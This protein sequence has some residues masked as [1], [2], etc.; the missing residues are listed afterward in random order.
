M[1][2]YYL[3]A[4]FVL[5]LAFAAASFADEGT[6]DSAEAYIK[7]WVATFN[8]NDPEQLMAFYDNSEQI[9]VIVS[10]GVRFR[11]YKAVQKAYRGD[12]KILRH[13]D[14]TTKGIS[15][16]ILGNTAIVTFEHL[17]KV[18]FLKDNAHWQLHVRTTSVL[19]RKEGKWKIV[20]DHSSPIQGI[21][22][23]KQIEE[24]KVEDPVRVQITKKFAPIRQTE[25][26]FKIFCIGYDNQ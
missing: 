16:R 11:G 12:Q 24:P 13:Y 15:T 14:S 25:S 7:D 3:A 22:R 2:W 1:R 10:S 17:F 9:E 20:L 6:A 8:K 18:R 4:A 26:L 23:M 5:S 21:E 19:R